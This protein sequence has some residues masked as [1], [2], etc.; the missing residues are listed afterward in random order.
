MTFETGLCEDWDNED[1]EEAFA[2]ACASSGTLASAAGDPGVAKALLDE[3]CALSIL[4]L[5]GSKRLELIHRCLV[6]I[7]ELIESEEHGGQLAMH[8]LEN[9]VVPFLSEVIY[10]LARYATLT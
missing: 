7:L 9:G 6:I 5:L 3:K 10:L 2:T 8:L 1:N 4:S